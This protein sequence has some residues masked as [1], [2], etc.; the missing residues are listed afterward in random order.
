MNKVIKTQVAEILQTLKIR[1]G[2]GLLI[3]SA[4]QFLG[5]PEGGP[6]MYFD[7]L[8]SILGPQGTIA[9]PT[10]NFA[11]AKGEDYDPLT[12]PSVGM[13]VFSEYVRLH[14]DSLR[15]IHPMQSLSVIG[16]H[17]EDLAERDT[18]SAFED[19]SAFDRMLGLDF[20]LLL[21]G[22]DIEASAIAHYS[23]QRAQVP[24]RY[25][26]EFKGRVRLN[27]KWESRTYRMFARDL[28]I[29]PDL[30]G[31]HVQTVLES[32]GLWL[33]QPLN[34]GFISVCRISDFIA[35]TDEILA[36]DP[37]GL[38]TNRP[39]AKSSG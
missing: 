16:K 13:G 7:A 22:A 11:F 19:G 39:V 20:K 25:W 28:D 32:K 2:D 35:A 33:Q 14:P 17:A 26:K 21:L 31:E 4:L 30:T 34:Y 37:W 5:L 10:F 12:T 29:D 24:Y 1:S 3:H 27:E 6:S 15:T 9:V 23:E 38:V 18:P 36:H 8:Q